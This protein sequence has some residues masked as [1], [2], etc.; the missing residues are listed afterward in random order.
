MRSDGLHRYFF[1]RRRQLRDKPLDLLY[2]VVV[3]FL[4]FMQPIA[5]RL[6]CH[7]DAA[8]CESASLQ[9]LTHSASFYTSGLNFLADGKHDAVFVARGACRIVYRIGE[10]LVLKLSTYDSER[11]SE[12]IWEEAASLEATQHLSQTPVFMFAG[13]CHIVTDSITLLERCLLT[14]YEGVSLDR[15]MQVHFA[16][17]YNHTTACFFV[18]AYQELAIMV[19]DGVADRLCYVDLYTDNV[20]TNAEPTQHVLGEHIKVTILGTEGV[21]QGVLSRRAFNSCLDSLFDDIEQQCASAAH[22]SWH[23][24]CP[25]LG[26]YF[27]SFFKNTSQLDLETVRMIC[28]KTF[29][30][31]WRDVSRRKNLSCRRHSMTAEV[32]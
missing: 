2:S 17:P 10:S 3:V 9:Q 28:L 27:K 19:I 4:F 11:R 23:F 22:E 12:S 25:L 18:T 14:S 5:L 20:A 15:L 13:C 24:F 26:K 32:I 31:L 7:G 30:R 16:L 1:F 21:V 6:V 8:R 29:R